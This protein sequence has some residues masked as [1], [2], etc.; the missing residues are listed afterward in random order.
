MK[1]SI[2]N[3]KKR[4][5]KVNNEIDSIKLHFKKIIK[6]KDDIINQLRK[7]IEKLKEENKKLH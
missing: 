1:I 2:R 7:E 3:I 4:R 6:E 5:L